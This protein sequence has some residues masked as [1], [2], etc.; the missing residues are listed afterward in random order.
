MLTSPAKLLMSSL[1]PF[2]DLHR[3][4]GGRDRH[5]RREKK[6]RKHRVL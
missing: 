3:L 1:V 2:G 6:V 5:Q 4:I